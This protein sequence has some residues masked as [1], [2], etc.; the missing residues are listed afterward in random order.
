MLFQ[1]DHR[2]GTHD[3]RRIYAWFEIA[4]TIIDFAAATLF[5]I[6]SFMFLSEE[7][8]MTGTWCFIVGSFFFAAKPTL[9][10]VRELKLAAM[11]DEEDLAERFRS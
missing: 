8:T 2:H 7:W 3:Q 5:V 11:G 9:R 6:G 1:T 10:L 4:Y